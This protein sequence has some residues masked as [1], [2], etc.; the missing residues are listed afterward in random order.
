MVDIHIND[1]NIPTKWRSL[2]KES[3]KEKW[4]IEDLT[5]FIK[6]LNTSP[7]QDTKSLEEVVQHLVTNIEDIWFKYSKMVNITRHS[8]AWWN[9]DCRHTLQ[10][11]LTILQSRKL[12]KFQKYGQEVQVFIL[13]WKDRWNH[14][15]EMWPM[16]TYELDQET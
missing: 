8:K 14:K 16:R 11:L 1:E 7:I 5:W 2:V 15:Q 13:Q 6:N 10:K 9:K 4:F 3:N 12:E